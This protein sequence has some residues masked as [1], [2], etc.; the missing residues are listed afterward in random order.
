VL[1]SAKI[2][3]HENGKVVRLIDLARP[4]IDPKSPAGTFNGK[5]SL[6]KG[7]TIPSKVRDDG[8]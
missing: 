3:H 7:K 8:T 2:A 5:S 4:T 1:F 6:E